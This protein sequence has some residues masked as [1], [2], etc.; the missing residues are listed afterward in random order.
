MEALERRVAAIWF[1]RAVGVGLVGGL[2]VLVVRP[3]VPVPALAAPAVGLGLTLVWGTHAA[4]RYRR[5]RFAL[6]DDGLYL[7]RGVLVHVSTV[8]PYVRV[9]HVDTRRDP[10]ERLTGLASTV[11]YTAGARDPDLRVPGLSP[12]RAAGLRDRLRTL[13]V[14]RDDDAT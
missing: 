6:D 2:A 7:E 8:V 4:L 14:A 1:L 12:G 10:L 13:A 5:F 9:Q 11:V 3:T